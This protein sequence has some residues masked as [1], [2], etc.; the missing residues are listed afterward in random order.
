MMAVGTLA[1]TGFPLHGRAS[2][3]RTRSS[4]P[5]IGRTG[6]ARP[7]PSSGD[8]VAAPDLVLFL[9]AVLHD[10]RR[11]ARA[12]A[13]HARPR[14]AARARDRGARRR[15]PRCRT[16]TPRT[17][18]C[19]ATTPTATM[20]SAAREPLVMLVPLGVLALGALFAGFAFKEAFIG[21]GYDAFWKGA[22][23]TARTTTS[24]RDPRRAGLGVVVAVVMMALGFLL[25]LW[26]YI[27][28]APAR[29]AARRASSRCSTASCSTSGTS[30]SSTTSSSSGPPSGSGACSGRSAT[31]ASSTGS[32]PTA[33]RRGCVD[34]TR[35]VVRLQTGYV[36]HYAFAMLI[37]V[38]A[39]FTWYLV[40]AEG[41]LM[42]GLGILSGLL[43]LP[44]V[45]AAVHPRRCAATR[46]GARQRPLGGA[47]RHDRD[48]PA[49]AR[50]L[51]AV[52]SVLAAFQLVENIAGSPRRSASS[53]ASTASRCRSC[54]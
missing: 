19:T 44:L 4:R 49:L 26:F 16:P 33:S 52:R 36:Y 10:L 30:T 40:P 45:G 35:G 38:A 12:G 41:R 24:P 37:G 15:R 5:P 46:R 32:G 29:G 39:L 43:I 11:A 9:A 17:R 25:A 27:F 21:D 53:S 3:P 28:D 47:R 48:L 13:T 23:F 7:S 42:F 20:A 51:G 2:T 22:L 50:G 6:R 1:L 34:V 18:R 14:D 31:C 8:V 54:C